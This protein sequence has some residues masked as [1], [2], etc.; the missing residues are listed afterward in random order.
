[1][2]R[3]LGFFLPA[4]AAPIFTVHIALPGLTAWIKPYDLL[5]RGRNRW[6]CSGWC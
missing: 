3:F 5:L 2:M 6:P 1:M 4:V